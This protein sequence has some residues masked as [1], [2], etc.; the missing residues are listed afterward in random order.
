METFLGRKGTT[1]LYCAKCDYTCF[2]QSKYDRHL[3]TAKH[4]RKQ[5][6]TKIVESK[7]QCECGKEYLNRS[8]LFKHKKKCVYKPPGAKRPYGWNLLRLWSELYIFYKYIIRN[9]VRLSERLSSL[10]GILIELIYLHSNT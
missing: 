5:M 7:I 3:G 8:G 6:E 9:A 10:T 1:I 4:R 2:H